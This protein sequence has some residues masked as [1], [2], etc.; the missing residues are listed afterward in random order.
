MKYLKLKLQNR[1][2]YNKCLKISASND[3]N[4]YINK[5]A[6][7]NNLGLLKSNSTVLINNRSEFHGK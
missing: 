7:V 1:L 2:I 6:E 5:S 3:H 4:K